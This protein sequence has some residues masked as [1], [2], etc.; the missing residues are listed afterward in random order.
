MGRHFPRLTWLLVAGLVACRPG[1]EVPAGLEVHF[2]DHSD[3]VA[4]ADV[5]WVPLYLGAPPRLC[6]TAPATTDTSSW[7]LAL[8]FRGH[9]PTT[10][11]APFLRRGSTLCF[12]GDWPAESTTAV[13]F[14]LCPRLAL[15][16]TA[17]PV[18]LPCRPVR[19]AARGGPFSPLAGEFNGLI[20][21]AGGRAP[22]DDLA[23]RAGA[24]GYPLLALRAQLVALDRLLRQGTADALLLARQRLDALDSRLLRHSVALQA[25]GDTALLRARLDQAE[26]RWEDAWRGLA[27][28][29]SAYDRLAAD[30]RLPVVMAQ[31]ALLAR[32]GAL[33]EALV[34]LRHELDEP[35]VT[36]SPYGA[37]GL[38]LLAWLTLGD[39]H[40]TSDE[41]ATADAA[42]A[43]AR[44]SETV[45]ALPLE[46]ANLEINAALL[47]LAREV[48]PAP[49]LARA[50]ILL[51]AAELSPTRRELGRWAALAEART[52]LHRGALPA[53]TTGCRLLTTTATDPRLRA[54]AWGCLGE[55][56]E[57]RG[58]PLAALAAWRQAIAAGDAP[59]DLERRFPPSP[60]AQA[61]RVYRAVGAAVTAD[62]LT[63]A[64][65]LLSDLETREGAEPRLTSCPPTGSGPTV[66]EARLRADLG[67]LAGP[68]AE[69]ATGP[70]VRQLKAQLEE[71][72]A[73]RECDPPGDAPPEER[74]ELR[75]VPVADGVVLLARDTAGHV[76][77]V[78]RTPF[79]RHDLRRRTERL[80]AALEARDLDDA[81]YRALAAPLGDALAP[82]AGA[83]TVVTYGL[84]GLLQGVPLGALPVAG[85]WLGA[86][87]VP[88][89]VPAGTPR[90][91]RPALTQGPAVFVLDPER[92]LPSSAELAE[93]FSTLPPPTRLLRGAA[94]TR[95]AV[96]AAFRGAWRLHLGTHGHY[97]PAFPRLSFLQLAD[98]E[99]T[100]DDLV[101]AIDPNGGPELVDLA[102]CHTGRWPPTA[103]RGRFGLAGSL[104]RAGVPWAIGSRSSLD[105]RVAAH[106]ARGFYRA[107]EAGESVPRAFG[108]AVAGLT[109]S[110]R[111]VEWG[112]LTLFSHGGGATARALDSRTDGGFRSPA[113]DGS[114]GEGD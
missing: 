112:G 37:D 12:T 103:D 62:L 96:T 51:A 42:L 26:G 31:A 83:G 64:W 99:V 106:F 44:T 92:N 107:L 3:A 32:Q 102:G 89:V 22:A 27:R 80:A 94:A 84:Y 76:R 81:A 41:L 53:A 4:S 48:D 59:D 56:A 78:R 70:E 15:T 55:I 73:E 14:T 54:D 21:A 68:G 63:E 72:V 28:A 82:P 23:R 98:G 38:Q 108:R 45:R 7:R 19:Y 35:G 87:V 113:R 105:D 34:R 20:S 11:E 58:Q 69:P 39:P 33:R 101:S 29:R 36:A 85:G 47:A 90:R 95:S 52:A 61:E 18:E 91:P 75:A 6:L 100:L 43:T 74:A 66:R 24:A 46:A 57:R 109:K 114:P 79:A 86:T 9:R 25:A 10:P 110:H 30:G 60:D 67:T 97:D 93:L 88:V 111:A 77:L 13:T 65:R 104:A 17:E 5:S 71:L 2:R 40:A 16:R 49:T 8:G 50:R 1:L